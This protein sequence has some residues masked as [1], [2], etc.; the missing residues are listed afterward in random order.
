MRILHLVDIFDTRD[1]RDQVQMVKLCQE[2]GYATTVITSNCDSDNN[3]R[4]RDYFKEDDD[5]LKPVNIVRTKG[6]KLKLPSFTP[7]LVILPHPKLFRHYDVIHVYTIG[8]HYSFISY[9]LKLIKHAKV[10]MRAEL[11]SGLFHR[12]E[13]NFLIRKVILMLLMKADALYAYT[14]KEK[15]LLVQIGITEDRISIIPVGVYCEEFSK[16]Q[17]T[18]SGTVVIGYLGR[19]LPFKGAHRLVQPLGKLMVEYPDVR[20]LFAGPKTDVHYADGIINAMSANPNFSYLG[21]VPAKDFLKMCDIVIVPSL[22]NGLETGSIATLEAMAA[23]KAVIAS[24]GIPMNEYIKHSV[25]GLLVENDEQFYQ[26]CK[27]LIETP[28]FREQLGQNAQKRS[29]QYDWNVISDKLE[30]IYNSVVS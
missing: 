28:T 7:R 3:P 22:S 10:V 30:Q 24:N 16:A 14:K 6:F 4:S 19:F 15:E 29:L 13:S 11:S 20:V 9:F 26:Y 5:S 21:Y 27:E 8:S 17:K 2:R 23:G 25:S 12:T 1:P 18:E